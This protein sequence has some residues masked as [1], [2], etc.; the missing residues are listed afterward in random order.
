MKFFALFFVGIRRLFDPHQ[1]VLRKKVEDFF[2]IFSIFA[3][4]FFEYES[5][6]E[7]DVPSNKSRKSFFKEKN[8]NISTITQFFRRNLKVLFEMKK[9]KGCRSWE[10]L[11]INCCLLLLMFIR[12]SR[13]FIRRV[14]WPS[15]L[16]WPSYLWSRVGNHWEWISD[17][18][19][20]S[21]KNGKSK[22]I[23]WSKDGFPN[24][25]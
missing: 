5:Q 16:Q 6:D 7:V 15:F 24:D 12:D 10:W 2:S 18:L 19:F 3:F 17:W 13:I 9:E 20:W 4:D 23:L 14:E 8:W 22:N 21:K 1:K 11:A 25:A